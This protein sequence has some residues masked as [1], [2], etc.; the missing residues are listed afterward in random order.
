MLVRIV[1]YFVSVLSEPIVRA[2]LSILCRVCGF[3][4]A[5]VNNWAFRGPPEFISLVTEAEKRLRSED[6]DLLKATATPYTVMY[7]PTK[8][9][10]FP[11]WRYFG[12]SRD[13]IAWGC[14]GIIA[15]WVLFCIR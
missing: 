6:S 4:S 14:N 10:A 15:S 1:K 5:R 13:F 12:I 11:M 7:S 2:T 8:T 9:F 3:G